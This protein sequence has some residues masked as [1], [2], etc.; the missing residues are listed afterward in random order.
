MA[1]HF[2]FID[3]ET[4][5]KINKIKIQRK[6]CNLKNSPSG[7]Y[8]FN[9][10]FVFSSLLI[11]RSLLHL[12]ASFV[13]LFLLPSLL[14]CFFFF[15]FLCFNPYLEGLTLFAFIKVMSLLQCLHFL[16]CFF[17]VIHPSFIHSFLFFRLTSAR[18]LIPFIL[19]SFSIGSNEVSLS[20]DEMV[21]SIL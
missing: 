2:Y 16:S 11:I 13:F 10:F 9:V 15:K 3:R 6:Y 18:S 14:F 20:Q 4:V 21:G 1:E 19:I 5:I 8:F 12:I 7:H 17:Y